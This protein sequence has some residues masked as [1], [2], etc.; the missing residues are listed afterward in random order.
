MTA[1]LATTLLA[2]TARA[3]AP[4]P[5]PE[6][7]APPQTE[8]VH[9]GWKIVAADVAALTVGIV[10]AQA[11]EEPAFVLAWP[12]AAPSVHFAHGDAKGGVL[13]LALHV[14]APVAGGFIGYQVETANCSPGAWFCGLGGLALGVAGGM[15]TATIVDAAALASVER[16]VKRFTRNIP[17]PTVAVAP[18]GGFMVGLAGRL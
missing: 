12:L 10:A 4:A 15:L 6:T 8:V 5:A 18:G 7:P 11:T 17:L 9:F 3:D 16:P 13:S 1:L 14:F 2:A